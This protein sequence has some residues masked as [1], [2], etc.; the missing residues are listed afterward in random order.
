M[1]ST[2][3]GTR[4]KLTATCSSSS[5]SPSAISRSRSS[6]QHISAIPSFYPALHPAPP[7]IPS[8]PRHKPHAA[9][10]Y[11]SSKT[12]RAHPPATVSPALRPAASAKTYSHSPPHTHCSRPSAQSLAESR[13]TYQTAPAYPPAPHSSSPSLVDTSLSLSRTTTLPATPPPDP[14][15]SSATPVLPS[16]RMPR[17]PAT[18]ARK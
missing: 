3:S 4:R 15:V 14:P 5:A 9:L 1:V 2:R 16:P 11:I 17:K 18:P 6:R 10:P 13:S 8:S 7:H 12:R